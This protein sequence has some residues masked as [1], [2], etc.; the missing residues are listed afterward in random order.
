MKRPIYLDHHATTPLDPRVLDAMLP[1]LREDF[2]NP[3][4]S[5]HLYGW[6]AEAALSDAR[7]RLAAAIGAADPSE[8]VFTSGTTESDNLALL[9]VLRAS[10]ETRRHL[11]TSAVEHPAV[12]DACRAL[13]AE[14]VEVSRLPVDAEG[15]LDAS[16]VEAAIGPHTRLV[17]VGAAN[18]EVGTVQ[19]LEAITALCRER[20]V[21]FHS[22][23]AQWVGKLPV[24]VREMGIDLL[25]FCAHKIYGPK[26][27]G[28][29]YVRGGRPRIPLQPILHGGGHQA[30]RRSGTLPVAQCVGFARALE[31]CVEE[32]DAE[33]GRQRALRDRLLTRLEDA[34]PGVWRNGAREGGLP[35]NLNV[36]FDG[37]EADA[38]LPSL[39]E[40]ALSTGSACA[41][42]SAE[43]SHVLV[44]LGLAVDRV[45]GALRVG[46]G[47][48][49]REEDVEFT[50]QRLI[51][52][53]RRARGASSRAKLGASR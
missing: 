41:S 1:Y 17:S 29:L 9:G 21:P 25:A 13:E 47:R 31:L 44:A 10:R 26:G 6:R 40:L 5:T 32:Q 50:A 43:P 39:P 38:L 49:T 3:A 28:A 42:A 18:G 37:V 36:S 20:G 16:L 22:D 48:G 34:L 33:A 53:V 30:G 46:L 11:V 52:E 12:L 4:S 23:G 14:G 7:E 51:E 19:A 24:S 15:R 2:G 8:I 35:G 27:I 45:R